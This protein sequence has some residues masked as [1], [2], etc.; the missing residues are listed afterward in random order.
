MK[1]LI[2]F[3]TIAVVVVG[4]AVFAFRVSAA[5][6]PISI[7]REGEG[8][9]ITKA[10]S[11][12]EA[13]SGFQGRTDTSTQTAV[14][15]TPATMGKRVV[16]RFTLRNQ[17]KTCPAAD[18]SAEGEGAFSITVDSTDTQA[19]GTNTIHMVMQAKAKYKGQVND[20]AY[21]DGPVK[22]DIDYTYTVSGS[23][24]G[25][26][27]A[28]STP[29]GTTATQH[30]TIQ[31]LV[32]R[33]MTP[34]D[35]NAF[36][37]GDPTQG[38]ASEAF[39]VGT[40]LAYWAGVYYSVAQAEWRSGKCVQISFSPPSNTLRP[41]L[42]TQATVKTEVKTK[43]GERV[44]AKFFD[45]HAFQGASVSP[46][47]G[48][49]TETSPLALTYTAPSTKP[50]NSSVKAAFE[51][52]ATSRAGIAREPWEANLG[53]GWSGQIS[54]VRESKGGYHDEQQSSSS[55]SVTRITMDLKDGVGT[56]NGYAEI[57]TTGTNLR[58]V[59]RQGYV[60]DN[61]SSMQGHAEGSRDVK[62]NVTFSPNGTYSIGYEH[63]PFPEGKQHYESC[64]HQN[65][66]RQQDMGFY[67]TDCFPPGGHLSGSATDPNQLHGSINDVKV[68]PSGNHATTQTWTVNW[69]LARQG[70]SQ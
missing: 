8:Y 36:E 54:C 20:D 33:D 5:D 43:R 35:V 50:S 38:H 39:S 34:P 53:T 12:Q 60:F 28:L 62:V 26:N 51:V 37:G 30:I 2:L 32:T 31:F 59:A 66:C 4:L 48:R 52:T 42:G 55:Y 40:A 14:G 17:I 29:A 68:L 10:N 56:V 13:P 46:S 21:L 24:R 65:G 7:P 58:P 61:S 3:V 67:V 9:Q 49:S 16:S 69:D 64:D 47:Q 23:F 57:D 41:A 6:G 22:A 63:I 27:G 11:S 18:G 45:I 1:T 25:A 44:P 70:T 15:N 19:S